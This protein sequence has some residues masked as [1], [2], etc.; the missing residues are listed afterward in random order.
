MHINIKTRERKTRLRNVILG[1]LRK[2]NMK[3][4]TFALAACATAH[5][6]YASAFGLA[7]VTDAFPSAFLAEISSITGSGTVERRLLEC[8][9]VSPA[10]GSGDDEGN[11]VGKSYIVS[12]VIAPPSLSRVAIHPEITKQTQGG[13]SSLVQ[14][15]IEF[16]SL[17]LPGFA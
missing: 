5:S 7:E 15:N 3:F 9:D 12:S 13:S 4:T 2:H 6:G 17:E 11:E 1:Q 8:A 16:C 14:R 10:Q